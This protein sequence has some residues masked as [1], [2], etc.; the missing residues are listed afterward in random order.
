V[1]EAHTLWVD[2]CS[3]VP[4]IVPM[5]P[6]V[7]SYAELTTKIKTLS[8]NSFEVG[9]YLLQMSRE[10]HYLSSDE[11]GEPRYRAF[12]EYCEG[13]LRKSKSHAYAMMRAHEV[14]EILREYRCETLPIDPFTV[15][16]LSR[17]KDEEQIVTCW[18]RACT[19]KQKGKLPSKSDV[20]REVRQVLSVPAKPTSESR[21][22]AT[23]YSAAVT[24]AV[25]E[26]QEM[27]R[28]VD[29]RQLMKAKDSD[30]KAEKERLAAK[31][32]DLL[33]TGM[34]HY[35]ALRGQK[36]PIVRRRTII[37]PKGFEFVAAKRGQTIKFKF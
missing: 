3:S 32:Q 13:E 30:A 15:R 10:R 19:Q 36:L 8:S 33:R 29:F 6:D 9:G 5:P 18:E 26:M 14:Y 22:T 1:W 7:T 25:K 23:K 35:M 2:S 17:L 16:S 37:T 31:L 12:E 11:S 21:K 4:D 27:M 28:D 34:L 24:R 20:D